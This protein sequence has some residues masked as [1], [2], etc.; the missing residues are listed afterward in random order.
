M[1][2]CKRILTT[3]CMILLLGA[4][5]YAD[6][7]QSLTTE[8]FGANANQAAVL[9]IEPIT[10]EDPQVSALLDQFFSL[11]EA[12]FDAQS[13]IALYSGAENEAVLAAPQLRSAVGP[14]HQ[15][16]IDALADESTPTFWAQR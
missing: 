1:N 15:E 7:S 16:L 8:W 14:T 12:D 2:Y 9:G 13:G 5:V 11:R 4:A 10:P 3:L 6:D